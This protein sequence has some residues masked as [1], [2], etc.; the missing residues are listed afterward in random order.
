M[1]LPVRATFLRAW[2]RPSSAYNVNYWGAGGGQKMFG[3]FKD[4]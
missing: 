2:E 1:S 4:Q 3:H